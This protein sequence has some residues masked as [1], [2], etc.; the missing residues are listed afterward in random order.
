MGLCSG[1]KWLWKSR[2]LPIIRIGVY[3]MEENKEIIAEAVEST[4]EATEEAEKT[5][6]AV[7]ETMDDYAAQLTQEAGEE[8][9]ADYEDQLELTV[10]DTLQKM[11][12]EKTIISGKISGIVNAGAIMEVE[13]IRGFIPASKLDTKYVKDTND[14]LGKKVDAIIITVDAENKRLV[15]SVRDVLFQRQRE[16]RNAKIASY[17]VGSV[18]SG[19][20]EKIESYGAF[21]KLEEGVSGLV[22]VS[23]ICEKKIASPKEVVKVGDTVKVKVIR[24]ENGKISLRMRGLNAEPVDEEEEQMKKDIAGYSAG[25]SAS[26]G[27][28]GLLK[29]IKL[30]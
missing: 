1:W 11:M 22:H 28:A 6:A 2:H 29:N 4:T 10:W 15:L 24:N 20:V 12:E 16:A 23:Q 19:T 25:G 27:L 17:E 7:E 30:D 3:D 5:V 9:M 21:V 18:L 13:G 26:T 8:T 14:Y